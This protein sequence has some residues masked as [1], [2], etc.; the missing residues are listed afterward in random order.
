M[1]LDA[2]ELTTLEPG[3]LALLIV[4]AED[5]DWLNLNRPI[6]AQQKLRVVLWVEEALGIPFKFQSPDLHDWVSHFV[7]CPD[8]VPDFALEGLRVGS[9]WWPGVAWTGPG[10]DLALTTLETQAQVLDPAQNYDSL[11][12]HLKQ[13]VQ[14]TIR[15]INIDSVRALWRVRWAVA[16]ARH[17][18]LG[19]LDNAT[20]Y[21]PGWFP[22]TAQ[23]GPLHTAL[24]L[25]RGDIDRAID[26]EFERAA[27]A[28]P[29]STVLSHQHLPRVGLL[30]EP[31][32]HTRKFHHSPIIW[33]W[34]KSLMRRM[35]KERGTL[36]SW[37]EL[38]LFASLARDRV[39]WPF[40][41]LQTAIY[42]NNEHGL[43]TIA[44]DNYP[45]VLGVA[46]A[47]LGDTELVDRWGF[48]DAQGDLTPE[49]IISHLFGSQDEDYW[50]GVTIEH[51]IETGSNFGWH[52]PYI[53]R[54]AS[55]AVLNAPDVAWDNNSP[56]WK[57]VSRA[58]LDLGRDHSNVVQLHSIAASAMAL[59]H[60]SF[61]ARTHYLYLTST[62][63]GETHNH[64][65]HELAA[66]D[67]LCSLFGSAAEIFQRSPVERESPEFH[68]YIAAL[69]AAGEHAK[70]KEVLGDDA[71]DFPIEDPQ[72]LAR[73]YLIERLRAR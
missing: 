19:V 25:T 65:Q 32:P 13:D 23:Q 62:A 66:I 18:G 49:S 44:P 37:P 4:R 1:L 26:A 14:G 10:L 51:V 38:A 45:D 8:G 31:G 9:T 43:R 64:L 6:F 48:P 63:L 58:E 2:Q 46:A 27:L 42:F 52:T 28:S 50:Q 73:E 72:D 70:V 21:T 59:T 33:N 16:E 7:P 57:I 67:L 29:D 24:V 30:R 55:R 69:R 34:R 11:V 20:L 61:E 39:I 36:W 40:K 5:L 12:Q 3:A 17:R 22:V 53:I 56:A 15:W 41:N 54:A 35:T 71:E 60:S 68:L 47:Y